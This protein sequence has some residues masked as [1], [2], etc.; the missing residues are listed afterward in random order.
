VVI[1]KVIWVGNL[2]RTPESLGEGTKEDTLRESDA[3]TQIKRSGR[4]S[5]FKKYFLLLRIFLNYI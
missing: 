4:G 1:L 3:I 5:L 2:L